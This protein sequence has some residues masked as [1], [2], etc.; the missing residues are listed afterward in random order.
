MDSLTFEDNGEWKLYAEAKTSSITAV[1]FHI[2]VRVFGL[3]NGNTTNKHKLE[4]A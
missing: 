1:N 2:L 3:I 4:T